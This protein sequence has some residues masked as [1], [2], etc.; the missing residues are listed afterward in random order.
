MPAGVG[1]SRRAVAPWPENFD[2]CLERSYGSRLLNPVFTKLVA[3]RSQRNAEQARRVRSVAVGLFQGGHDE[4]PLHFIHGLA[5]MKSCG[6]SRLDAVVEQV[7]RGDSQPA[8]QG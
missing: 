7:G 2:R 3:Q 8:A 4:L 6:L 5:R 1:T